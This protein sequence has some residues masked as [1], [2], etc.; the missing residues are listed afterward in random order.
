M[1]RYSKKPKNLARRPSPLSFLSLRVLTRR[2]NADLYRSV[3]A[4]E[5]AVPIGRIRNPP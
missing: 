2:S 3:K 4:S 5:E 1:S